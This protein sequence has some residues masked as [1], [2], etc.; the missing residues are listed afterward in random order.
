MLREISSPKGREGARGNRGFPLFTLINF[1]MKN[2]WKNPGF[3][4]DT[5]A[6]PGPSGWEGVRGDP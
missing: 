6:P 3:P 4:V 2:S 5:A 1:S